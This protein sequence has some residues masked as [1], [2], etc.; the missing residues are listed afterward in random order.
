MKLAI[1]D[2][3]GT[4]TQSD[5]ADGECFVQSL[6]DEFGF[7]DVDDD[8]SV[9]PH[10]TDSGILAAIFQERTGRLPTAAEV[11]QFQA[12]FISRLRA[13]ERKAPFQPVPGA[14][15]MLDQ[16]LSSLDWT[17]ALA[18]GAWEASA[19]LKLASAGLDS[20]PLPGAF[21]D[22]SPVRSEIMQAAVSRV[23]HT[24]RRTSFDALVYVGDGVWD[25]RAC[26][27][28]GWP[29]IGIAA[30]S[31]RAARLLN[32][33]AKKVFPHYLDWQSFRNSLDS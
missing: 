21:A 23:M 18:S 15:A 29:F 31:V 2:V 6:A 13:V 22:D 7:V 5:L 4:L 3:D 20:L 16:L 14:R 9:Y 24:Q 10:C 25:A 1:F 27:L 33:G 19:R 8:W 12:R 17:V 30:D 26:R 32:E 28:L 11:M